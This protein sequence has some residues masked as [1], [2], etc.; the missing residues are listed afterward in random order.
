MSRGKQIPESKGKE[1]NPNFHLSQLA[2]RWK[3]SFIFKK[4][5]DRLCMAYGWYIHTCVYACSVV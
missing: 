2:L 5:G 1:E 4:Q 3:L